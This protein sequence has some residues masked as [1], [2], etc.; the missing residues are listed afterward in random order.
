MMGKLYFL[1][2]YYTPNTAQTNRLMSFVEGFSELGI[3]VELVFILSDK[4]D[5]KLE[6]EYSHITV[7]YMWDIINVKNR[8]LA[9]FTY[10]YLVYL[11]VNKLQKGDNVIL[12]DT[13]RAIFSLL[14]K[15][16]V[17]VYAE[18]T[19]HP[20]AFTVRT[21]NMRRYIKATK[22]LN[23][24]FVI[25]SALKNYFIKEGCQE[26]QVHIINMTVDSKRFEGIVRKDVNNNYIAYCGTATNNKDG[27]DILIKAFAQVLTRY[28]D[29]KLL[30]IGKGLDKEDIS[31]NQRLVAEL[32][33]E[34]NVVFTGVVPAVRIPQLLKDAHVLALA[35]PNNI[36]A[37]YGFPTKLGE[38]L[39]TSNPVVVTAV[40]DIPKFFNHQEN[41]IIA[42]PDNPTDFAEKLIW[43]I[44]H[45]DKAN[46]IASRGCEVAM[47]QFNYLYESKK[48]AEIIGV[49]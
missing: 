45:G 2:T 25:S 28:P 38:Y 34:D 1:S 33:I 37:E 8:Y 24:L 40:G 5:S 17:N 36:Q 29:Y 14:R 6:K 15:S 43:V 46:L 21:I 11:F 18:R 7:T 39:L 23:G 48:I 44:E 32:N 20:Y 16:G 12:F 30:I 49:L 35:R 3:D 42:E 26:D 41:I 19:E 13:S 31:G 9:Q 4:N 22:K 47:K 10:S 27:V